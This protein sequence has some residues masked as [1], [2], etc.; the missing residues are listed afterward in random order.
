M[1]LQHGGHGVRVTDERSIE[2]PPGWTITTGYVAIDTARLGCR[3]RMAIGDVEHSM[4]RLLEL[5]ASQPWPCPRGYWDHDR[6]VIVDGRHQ[7]VAALLLG[8]E[9][10]LVAWP[11]PPTTDSNVAHP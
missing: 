9:H 3:D 4:R 8:H 5:G 10:L 11:S 7:Y 6:F 1:N 2:L